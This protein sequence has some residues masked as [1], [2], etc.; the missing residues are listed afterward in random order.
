MI[1]FFF[2]LPI[3]E[4]SGTELAEKYRQAEAQELDVVGNDQLDYKQG[5]KICIYWFISIYVYIQLPVMY[6]YVYI[7]RFLL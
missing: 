7:Y 1:Y 2:R 3:T 4:S 6:M 5:N